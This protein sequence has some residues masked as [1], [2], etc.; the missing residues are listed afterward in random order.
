MKRKGILGVIYFWS[1]FG[2]FSAAIVY[3]PET[4]F[5]LLVL[6]AIAG[7]SYAIYGLSIRL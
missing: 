1:C 3:A 7:I 2:L 5:A 4:L 6:G